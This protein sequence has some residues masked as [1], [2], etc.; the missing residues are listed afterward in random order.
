MV[1]ADIGERWPRIGNPTLCAVLKDADVQAVQIIV[2]IMVNTEVVLSTVID[3]RCVDSS[4][5]FG[6]QISGKSNRCVWDVGSKL[7]LDVSHHLKVRR[8]H[9][10]WYTTLKKFG[11]DA[12]ENIL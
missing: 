2:E 9:N 10:R 6:D 1:R 12:I 11:G 5:A 3:L 8:R 4:L 7:G